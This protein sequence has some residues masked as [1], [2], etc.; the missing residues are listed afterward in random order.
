M[1]ALST[2]LDQVA[3]GLIEVLQQLRWTEERAR[4]AL[5]DGANVREVVT[6]EQIDVRATVRRALTEASDVL[7]RVRSEKIRVLVDDDG[8][9]LSQV[10]AL[11]GHPPRL[12]KRLYE[13]D[14]QSEPAKEVLTDRRGPR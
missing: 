5:A 6:K 13:A 14:E 3:A 7:R 10:A 11:L 1:L 8:L 12:V 9:S 2:E 4:G